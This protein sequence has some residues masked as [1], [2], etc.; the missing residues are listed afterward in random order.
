MK[1]EKTVIGVVTDVDATYA[2]DVYCRELED[3][4]YSVYQGELCFEDDENTDIAKSLKLRKND[5]VKI[6]LYKMSPDDDPD[7]YDEDFPYCVKILEKVE[8]V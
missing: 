1:Y 2:T 4:P 6:G 3:K 5:K 7:G 8:E